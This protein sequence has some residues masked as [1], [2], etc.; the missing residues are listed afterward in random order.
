MTTKGKKFWGSV[1][2]NN[3][4]RLEEK[5]W[6]LAR[7]ALLVSYRGKFLFKSGHRS[8]YEWRGASDEERKMAM[9]ARRKKW[10]AHGGGA[11][12]TVE[13]KLCKSDGEEMM[14]LVV[15][16]RGSKPHLPPAPPPASH[17]TNLPSPTMQ[18]LHQTSN[19]LIPRS[20]PSDLPFPPPTLSTL[21]SSRNSF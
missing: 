19:F 17:L 14:P 9:E 11:A 2:N 5:P 6:Y 18:P 4:T 13:G 15:L 10:R 20:L 7:M 16:P 1:S 12:G 8:N 3:W 21:K